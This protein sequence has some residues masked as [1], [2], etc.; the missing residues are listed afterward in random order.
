MKQHWMNITG[1]FRSTVNENNNKRQI[2][3]SVAPGAQEYAVNRK[4]GFIIQAIHENN[5]N[6]T[7]ETY[8]QSEYELY[9]RFIAIDSKTVTTK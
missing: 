1:F 6:E 9:W 2:V 7:S 4:K 5:E 3:G 8:T